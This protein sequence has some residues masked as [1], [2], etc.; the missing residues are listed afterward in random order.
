MNKLK[1]MVTGAGSTMG[2]SVL[3]A[4]LMSKY[5][6]N[7]DVVV[8]NSEPLGASFFLSDKV[9]K[10]YLVPI[11]KDPNYLDKIIE[12]CKNEGVQAIFSG[13][14]HEIYAL[15]NGAEKIKA[16]TG[17]I[18]M[19]SRP[20]VVDIGTDKYRTYE[21]FKE[22]DLPYPDTVLF[23]DYQKLVDR[24]GYPIFMK[25]RT[26]S[27]SR[28]I[29]KI[30]NEKELFEKKFTDSDDIVLQEFL[31]S[32]VEYTVETFCDKTGKVVGTIPMRRELDYGMSYSGKIDRNEEAIAVAEKI[33]AALKPEGA[34]NVQLRMVNGKA[35]PFEIN[36]R[37]SSTEC[38]RAH[39]GFNS[40]E[41]A[42]ANY[43]FGEEIDLSNWSTG[44][45]MRYWH[46]CYFQEADIPR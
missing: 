12:I 9:T 21:F 33:G 11:A 35:V 46:E 10:R 37:F 28:N 3:K 16:E 32:D 17:A 26:S 18:V 14:E 45:F 4:L 15:A 36:T 41:A 6:E 24:V 2:Q 29:Y 27:G 38:V 1:V 42:I 30:H 44:M 43:V 23:D 34:L 7:L 19:L 5:N 8:T 25:P 31:D 13:T 40:V 22:H 20:E 39:Y